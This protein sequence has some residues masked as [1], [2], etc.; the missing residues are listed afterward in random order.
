MKYYVVVILT[1]LFYSC[2]KECF[3][4]YDSLHEKWIY[5]CNPKAPEPI[6]Y[7]KLEPGTYAVK[8]LKIEYIPHYSQIPSYQDWIERSF[9]NYAENIQEIR[10]EK[11]FINSYK[12]EVSGIP[13]AQIKQ[14]YHS[15]AGISFQ[16]LSS[17]RMPNNLSMGICFEGLT[18]DGSINMRNGKP[19]SGRL[20][21]RCSNEIIVSYTFEF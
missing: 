19:V 5:E 4:S 21:Y 3:W 14:S 20:D 13:R 18:V 9:K 17:Y 10:L 11:K 12:A 7:P 15:D 16:A 1:L 6:K 2:S 8:N